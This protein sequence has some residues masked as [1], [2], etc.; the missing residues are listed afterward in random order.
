MEPKKNPKADLTKNSSLY[1]VIGLFAVMLFTYVAFEWKTYDE[2]N[3]YDI[4]MNVDDLLDEEV[5]M[6]EQI[7]TPPPPPP[8]AA[9]EIIEVV[10]DEEEVEETVIES[11]ETS[12]EEEIVE[13]EDV[14]V[15]EIEEDVDVPFAVIEDVPVFPGCENESD[16]RACFNKMIQ[17]HI[18]KNFRYPEIAQEMGVQGRVSVMFVIQKDGSIGNVRMR[19][20]D[21]NLEAEAARIIN[22]LPKMTPGKQRGRAVRV[23]FSIPI[24]FKLQ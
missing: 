20:P 13:V 17:K 5:P 16:K 11:T 21:K 14:V 7:K 24:N 15:D 2:V 10:E 1:F 23:P 6:T 12:Q 3:D 19:G 18:G 8:P 4:S 22:K 9:P